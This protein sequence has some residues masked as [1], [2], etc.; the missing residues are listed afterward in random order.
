MRQNLIFSLFLS[1]LLLGGQASA[2]IADDEWNDTFKFQMK[3]AEYGSAKAQFSLAEMYEEGRGTPKNYAKAIK[4]YN[5][6][7]KNGHKHAA[8]RI[9]RLRAKMG[10]TKLNKKSVTKKPR[11][12]VKEAVVSKKTKTRKTEPG[13]TEPRKIAPQQSKP[14]VKANKKPAGLSDNIKRKKKTHLDNFEDA[15]E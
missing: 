13:K 11:L 4:W 9:I 3:M 2:E 12:K 14:V 8:S 15:F 7:Q 5:K 6:A 10:G 1:L